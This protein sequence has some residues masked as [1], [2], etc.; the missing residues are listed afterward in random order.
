MVDGTDGRRRTD[1]EEI[2]QP[3]TRGWTAR[4]D[5]R[6]QWDAGLKDRGTRKMIVLTRVEA[7]QERKREPTGFCGDGKFSCGLTLC[8]IY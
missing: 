1:D 5:H 2:L 8:L 3:Q 4:T 7:S 6:V